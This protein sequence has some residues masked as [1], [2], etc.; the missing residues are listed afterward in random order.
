MRSMTLVRIAASSM[1][2]IHG[3]YR[4][5]VG[6]PPGFGEYLASQHVPFGAGVA[7][8]LTLAEIVGGLLLLSGRFVR[9]LCAWFIL[10]LLAGIALVH[11]REGWF[12]VGGGRNGV[13]Y[14]VLLIACF[15]A[16][17]LDA[18]RASAAPASQAAP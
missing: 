9:P 4:L 6:G 16:V 5:A 3:S 17:A 14:S 8:A 10:E 13:E 2:V 18:P 7:W 15:A 12:V 1:M 11:A